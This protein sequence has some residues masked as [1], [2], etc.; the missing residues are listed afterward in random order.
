MPHVSPGRTKPRDGATADLS[1]RWVDIKDRR[2]LQKALQ[3]A[4]VLEHATIPPYLYALFSLRPDRNREVAGIIRSV[5]MQEMLHMALVANILNAIGATPQIAHPGTVPRYPGPLPGGVMP[6][7]TVSLRRCSVEHVREVF[8]AIETPHVPL[9]PA[10]RR[11]LA[12]LEAHDIILTEQGEIRD[13]PD[14]VLHAPRKFFQEAVYDDGTLGWFYQ[15]IAAAIIGLDTREALFTGDPARQVTWPDAPGR[16][17]RVTDAHT[18]LWA[19]LEIIRQGEGS[20]TDPTTGPLPRTSGTG[21]Q[22]AP[23]P[24]GTRR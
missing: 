10:G 5:V 11:A 3:T 4:L 1:A 21:P 13:C 19:V 16:L 17:Y 2:G 8:M 12:D 15:Q 22:S 6:D 9:N 24:E 23:A 14:E 20:P 18:A 7:L